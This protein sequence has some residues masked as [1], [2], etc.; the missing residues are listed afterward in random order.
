MFCWYCELTDAKAPGCADGPEGP[1]G[2]RGELGYAR[3]A[4]QLLKCWRGIGRKSTNTLFD[5][6]QPP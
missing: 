3:V 1:R 6:F 4:A 5:L 2:E